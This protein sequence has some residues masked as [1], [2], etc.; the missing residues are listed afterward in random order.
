[1]PESPYKFLDHYEYED[2]PIF[3]GR[4]RET[5]ILLADVLVSRLVVLF[6]RTGTG[7]TSLINAG[8]R[9]RLEE[10]GY[11]TF[12]IRVREDPVASARS[13]IEKQLDLRLTGS[14]LAEL[15][16]EV[17][18]SR[19]KESIVLF[20]DQFEEF[21]LYVRPESER[22]R[23]FIS[24]VATLSIGPKAD[25]HIIFSLRE[26]FFHE[27][28]EFREEIPTIFHSDSNLRLHW[29]DEDQARE[30]IVEPA[31]VFGIQIDRDLENRLILDLKDPNDRIEPA[32]LQ[33]VCDTLWRETEAWRRTGEKRISLEQ[34]NNLGRKES[35]ETIAVQLLYRRLEEM[36]RQLESNAQLQILYA[37]LPKLRT[38]SK[39]KYVRDVLGLVKELTSDDACLRDLIRD[40]AKLNDLVEQLKTDDLLLRDVIDRLTGVRFLRKSLRDNLDVV[41]LSHDY[42]VSAL[43]PLQER[44]KVMVLRRQVRE[45]MERR[46]AVWS[47]MAGLSS[48]LTEEERDALFMAR[49][50][51]EAVS[52]G[53]ALL[54]E[55]PQE[56]A[57]FLFI[58]GLEHGIDLPAWFRKA[59][60]H[61]VDVWKILEGQMESADWQSEQVRNALQLLGELKGTRALQLLEI[62]LRRPELAPV[63]LEVLGRIRTGE[64]LSLLEKRLGEE[65]SVDRVIDVLRRMRTP[66]AVKLLGTAARGGGLL[67]L[68][69][70]LTLERVATARPEPDPISQQAAMVLEDL[71]GTQA[72]PFFLSAL[73]HGQDLR[74]WFDKALESGADVWRMLREVVGQRDAPREQVDN[75]VRLLSSVVDPRAE[76]LLRR[77]SERLEPSGLVRSALEDRTQRGERLKRRSWEETGWNLPKGSA[78][79]FPWEALIDSIRSGKCLPILGP[80]VSSGTIL[81]RSEIA[82]DWARLY[83]YPFRDSS[84]LAGVAE[85]LATQKDPSFPKELLCKEIKR[86]SFEARDEPD[87]PHSILAVL[88]FSRYVT[89]NFDDLMAHALE[90]RGRKPRREYCRWN[91]RLQK[92]GG[93]G[94]QEERPAPESPVVFHFFGGVEEPQSLVLTEDDYM[95]L[96]ANVQ[97]PSAIP[98]PIQVAFAQD[99]LLFVGYQ[100]GEVDLRFL[101]R[102][103][104]SRPRSFRLLVLLPPGETSADEIESI[105]DFARDYYSQ[106]RIHL[107]WGTAREFLIELYQWNNL[108]RTPI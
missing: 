70:A 16:T 66:E 39:T 15:V 65:A 51:F 25:A 41:E 17:T 73:T 24:D 35:S 37:L 103:I 57:E 11:R 98:L 45:A 31:Y 18:A 60:S 71:L 107:Y 76:E 85:F 53:A 2:R 106:L 7:K 26:E 54:S 96:L 6:A 69:A 99:L 81:P 90:K 55:L 72:E 101:L 12:Y 62:G 10:R 86:L 21:F 5:R 61:G 75:A 63:V 97:E 78:S 38:P 1:M 8:V 64:A 100:M 29:F 104:R 102:A 91:R 87:D 49:T 28:N 32:Q 95:E 67:A 58:A 108:S 80:G 30:A 79:G 23:Q 50:D 77:A 43:E 83:G 93:E 44:V 36:F 33:I 92:E 59:S 82:R 4:E 47:R 9:P 3:F 105:L 89:T 52:D 74:F 20:F 84:N 48:P 13:E 56:E 40:P 46:G 22:G 88:P 94:R 42:L 19:P 27:M 34:Y 14:T 68:K